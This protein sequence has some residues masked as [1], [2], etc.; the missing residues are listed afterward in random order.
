LVGRT[1]SV[2]DQT[3]YD[4]TQ[5]DSLLHRGDASMT[6]KPAESW[7]RRAVP[8]PHQLTLKRQARC[9]HPRYTP[10]V[11]QRGRFPGHKPADQ[12]LRSRERRLEF[13]YAPLYRS[14]P[15]WCPISGAKRE[16]PTACMRGQMRP[17]AVSLTVHSA[18]TSSYVPHQVRYSNVC[19]IRDEEAVGSN[20]AA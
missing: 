7:V 20:L 8:P 14:A 19:V 15:W 9:L 10:G 4:S 17:V 18:L 12:A 11:W 5:R 2:M 6:P 3:S 13:C 16:R 1:E